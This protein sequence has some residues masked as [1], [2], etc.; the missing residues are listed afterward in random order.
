MEAAWDVETASGAASSSLSLSLSAAG[1]GAGLGL[2]GAGAG[3]SSSS[4]PNT[5]SVPCAGAGVGSS[6]LARTGS[7]W[8]SVDFLLVP[9]A[10]VGCGW[11]DSVSGF[12]VLLSLRIV[13]C[14][15]T[16]VRSRTAFSEEYM[17]VVVMMALQPLT[18][19]KKSR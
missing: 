12:P 19:K 7:F 8:A 14:N 11:V 3:T 5:L 9:L 6:L 18:L 13:V 15:D 16:Y 17:S 1:A 2:E 4:S 10:I